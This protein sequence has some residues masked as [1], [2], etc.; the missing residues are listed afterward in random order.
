MDG[1]AGS[2]K[3]ASGFRGGCP[4]LLIFVCS[5]LDFVV[6]FLTISKTGR[7]TRKEKKRKE[8]SGG[9]FVVWDGKQNGWLFVI[10]CDFAAFIRSY[11]FSVCG[12]GFL[13]YF[14]VYHPFF[15]LSFLNFRALISL[16]RGSLCCF[17]SPYGNLG[18]PS[19]PYPP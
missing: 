13:V 3:R 9:G 19:F 16:I 7:K 6:E 18:V 5:F 12:L 8:G 10:L 11:H 14:F 1:G 4:S 15:L 2:G 17:G